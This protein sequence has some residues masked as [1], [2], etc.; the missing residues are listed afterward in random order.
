MKIL[1]I[2]MNVNANTYQPEANVEVLVNIQE[3]QD[4][5]INMSREDLAEWFLYSYES[6]RAEFTSESQ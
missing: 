2:E 1:K 4:N 5:Y 3:L 6:A